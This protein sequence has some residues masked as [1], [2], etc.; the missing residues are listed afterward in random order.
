MKIL[1]TICGMHGERDRQRKIGGLIHVD[2]PATT[3]QEEEEAGER[4][5]NTTGGNGRERPSSGD[6]A[7]LP[8]KDLHTQGE[9]VERSQPSF[10]R[11]KGRSERTHGHCT[12]LIFVQGNALLRRLAHTQK[13]VHREQQ[14]HLYTPQK[15]TDPPI[16]HR[17][18]EEIS[19]DSQPH[20]H[21]TLRAPMVT[22]TTPM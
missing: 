3:L 7:Y 12:S 11:S 13:V 20:P 14:I 9:G 19:K 22:K 10:G 1:Y 6:E 18:H 5:R 15:I 2:H 17:R 4:T 8:L 16:H 21:F